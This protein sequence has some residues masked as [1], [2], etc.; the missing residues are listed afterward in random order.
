[1]ALLLDLNVTKTMIIESFHHMLDT[2]L[3]EGL[4]EV[5]QVAIL[6]VAILSTMDLHRHMDFGIV[7][8]W[9]PFLF[10]FHTMDLEMYHFSSQLVATFLL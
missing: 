8:P 7:I 4:G 5:V 3:M 6:V 2:F 1:M 9:F 10:D